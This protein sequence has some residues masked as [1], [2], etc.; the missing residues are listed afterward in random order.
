MPNKIAATL[1]IGAGIALG[2]TVMQLGNAGADAHATAANCPA[3]SGQTSSG[4]SNG[5]GTQPPSSSTGTSA[6]GSGANALAAHRLRPRG[7]HG[8]RL[9]LRPTAWG[10]CKRR[11]E[12][13][14]LRHQHHR[15]LDVELQLGLDL[16]LHR[17]HADDQ[18][19]VGQFVVGQY[20]VGLVIQWAAAD[21]R[22]QRQHSGCGCGGHRLRQ[23]RRPRRGAATQPVEPRRQRSARPGRI[24]RTSPIAGNA[25]LR[26]AQVRA[27]R[28]RERCCGVRRPDRGRSAPR[29]LRSASGWRPTRTGAVLPVAVRVTGRTG[30]G[31]PAR[32]RCARARRPHQRGVPAGVRPP[33]RFLR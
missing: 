13:E 24:A 16:R 20:V 26:P 21:D 11:H 1:L 27:T 8:R 3:T 4:T 30:G 10:E 33:R 18:F 25:C 31:V 28:R 19:V 14:Q 12:R 17:Q 32:A 23:R 6:S 29:R 7:H 9:D 22:R 5:N 15:H 2:A